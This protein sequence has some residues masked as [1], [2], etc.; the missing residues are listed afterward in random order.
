VVQDEFALRDF[1]AFV[2]VVDAV[3]VEQ[4]GAALD[5]VDF[6]ALAQQKFGEV[7]AVLAGDAGDEGFFGHVQ[8]LT[9]KL[10]VWDCPVFRGWLSFLLLAAAYCPRLRFT[11]F[12]GQA[13]A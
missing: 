6:V 9:T 8:R 1:G 10:E 3:G 7:G 11:C 13:C 12:H 4:R 2:Q 5:A